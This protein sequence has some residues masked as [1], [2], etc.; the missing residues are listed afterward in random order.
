MKEEIGHV[1]LNYEF[2]QGSDQYSDG[3]IEDE[4]LEYVKNTVDVYEILK[5]DNRWPI[6]Y[7]LSPVRQNILEWYDFKKDSKVLEIGA[8]C[9][10]ITGV[11]CKKAGKVVCND[12]SKRRSQINAYRNK[13]FDNLEIIVGNFN[14][15]VIEEK[16]DYI[17]LIGVLEYAAYYTD[18]QTPFKSFLEHIKKLLKPDGKVLIAIENK[19]GLKYWG[20]AKED[21]TGMMFDGI[22]GYHQTTSKARTFSKEQLQEIIKS[23]GFEE[24]EFFYPFPDY[25][26]P[27]QIFSGKYMPKSQDLICAVESFDNSRFHLFDETSAFVELVE[28]DKFDFFANSF[29]VEAGLR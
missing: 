3:D 17:T 18:S 23:A 4:L 26:F 9:G 6:L 8:G 5:K 11:L 14:D 21:H 24:Q 10:A 1:I 15:I 29:F 22:E 12:L 19:F 25:K 27:Q 13:E 7:H 2:Y 16:F 20:G 28:A